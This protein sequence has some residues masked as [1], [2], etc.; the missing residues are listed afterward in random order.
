VEPD[1]D[2]RWLDVIVPDDIRDLSRD[3]AAY[4][5][6]VRRAARARR[7][8]R[9]LARRGVV[10]AIAVTVA[11]AIAGLVAAMLTVLGPR[12]VTRAP[13][14]K[15]LASPSQPAGAVGGLLPLATLAGP[16]GAVSTRA[17]SLRP[18]V[19]ALVPPHCDC[20]DLLNGLAGQAYSERLQLAI[21]VPAASDDSTTALA[22]T[23]D[24]G[25]PS[26]Y[27]DSAGTIAKGVDG[28]GVTAVLVDLDG[29]IYAVERDITDPL[30]TTVDAALQSML[31]PDRA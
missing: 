16:H 15:P 21:V 8:R 4:R 5:R 30:L 20:R 31:L 2:A 22:S 7:R 10:P 19:L 13:A 23:L 14:A 29:T 24:R 27:F 11:V 25:V 3:I 26:V 17:E 6:E 12:N 9:L 28:H 18:A 1:A